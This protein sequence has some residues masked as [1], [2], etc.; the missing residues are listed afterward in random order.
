MKSSEIKPGM[1]FD[2]PCY[3]FDQSLWV[4]VDEGNYTLQ[5]TT[6]IEIENP[7]KNKWWCK[8]LGCDEHPVLMCFDPDFDNEKAF[9]FRTAPSVPDAASE[10]MAT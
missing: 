1:L 10:A 8:K 3:P 2:S 9:H 4:V 5:G 6:R 7:R